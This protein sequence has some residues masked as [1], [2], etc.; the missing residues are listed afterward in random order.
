[1]VGKFGIA[2]SFSI[3]FLYA[4]ELLPTVVRSQAMAWAS[5]VAG[6]GLLGFPYIVYLVT[7][8]PCHVIFLSFSCHVYVIFD[9]LYLNYSFLFIFWH[10]I[11][12][13]FL[14]H[15]TLCLLCVI[16]LWLFRLLVSFSC[17]FLVIFEGWG[18][19]PTANADYGAADHSRFVSVDL[20]T[21]N[22]GSQSAADSWGRR[23]LW[24]QLSHLQLPG[25]KYKVRPPSFEFIIFQLTL[26]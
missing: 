24:F 4:S 12:V 10:V 26:N 17:H 16:I 18:F 25:H 19:P 8:T 6:I 15:V 20:L 11:F 9:L 14:W 7:I 3:I 2:A 22:A 5:F 21:R 23:G 1:M 13:S